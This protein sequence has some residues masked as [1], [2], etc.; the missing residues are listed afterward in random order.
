M[1]YALFFNIVVDL[2]SYLGRFLDLFVEYP[3]SFDTD[4]F[5]VCL[6]SVYARL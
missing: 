6:F 3:K 5:S 4:L 2:K 1:Q